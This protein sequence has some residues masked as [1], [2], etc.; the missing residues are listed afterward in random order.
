MLFWAFYPIVSF[1]VYSRLFIQNQIKNPIPS[2]DKPYSVVLA[3]S[4]FG[5]SQSQSTN[6]G[7]Y[8]P[9]TQWF[10]RR[11]QSQSENNISLKEYSLSVQRLNITN[12]K[13]IVGGDDLKKSLIHY[14]PKSLP[15]EN[16]M[17]SIFGHSTLPQLY[18]V[19]NY[20]TIF[21]YLPSLQKGDT[22][23][24]NINGS[25]YE[26]EIYETFVVNPD[27]ISVLDQKNDASYLQLITCVPPGTYWKRLI[28]RAKLKQ[29]PFN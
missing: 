7:Y 22:V 24:A 21:T 2:S 6:L 25:S 1:E 4:V 11:P 8:I 18:D 19:K 17:I 16:G 20:K 12:A 26:Y 10:P 29:P 5:A 15:G 27:Q 9:S 13:V 14:L 28:V 23:L 3:S